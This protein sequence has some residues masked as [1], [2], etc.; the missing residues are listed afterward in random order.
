[1]ALF[2]KLLEIQAAIEGLKKDG[3]AEQNKYQYVTGNKLLGFVRPLMD[4]HGVLLVPEVI[5]A[6]YTRQDYQTRNGAKSEMFCALK[7]RFTWVD[8]ETGEKLPCEWASSGMNSSLTWNPILA[9]LS[10]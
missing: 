2:K 5:E 8:G 4:K 3:S 7:M 10:E 6:Q 1:M 9:N